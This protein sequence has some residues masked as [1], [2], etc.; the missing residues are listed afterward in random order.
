VPAVEL[1]IPIIIQT[2]LL[3]MHAIPF[4]KLYGMVN[5]ACGASNKASGTIND[6]CDALRNIYGMVNEACGTNNNASDV[7][8]IIYAVIKVEYR[9]TIEEW[10]FVSFIKRYK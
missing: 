2:V 1:A 8:N 7:V 9:N 6:P 10:L 5:E 3:I 4:S